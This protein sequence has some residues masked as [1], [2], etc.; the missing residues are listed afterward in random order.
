MEVHLQQRLNGC[1]SL[2]FGFF[3]DTPKRGVVVTWSP[4]TA[5]VAESWAPTDHRWEANQTK[6]SSDEKHHVA[7]Q[8]STRLLLELWCLIFEQ[9]LQRNRLI[10]V[11]WHVMPYCRRIENNDQT[12]TCGSNQD[13]CKLSMEW[14]LP[15]VCREQ[16]TYF[17]QTQCIT[18]LK[19]MENHENKNPTIID[20]EG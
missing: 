17:V 10:Q 12:E 15:C 20:H 16:E 9:H 14:F 19:T 6:S 4:A 18:I 11:V 3:L 1:L 13:V 5:P 2:P 8:L 7:T